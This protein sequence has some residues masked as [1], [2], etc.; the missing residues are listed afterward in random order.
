MSHHLAT[1]EQQQYIL[2]II[3]NA[4]LNMR[5]QIFLQYSVCISFEYIPEIKLLNYIFSF[6][7]SSMLFSVAT[8][9]IYKPI[10]NS[11]GLFFLYTFN[12]WCLL[13]F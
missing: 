13:S 6:L 11:Q 12:T 3:D 8:V 5:L 7:C 9:P 4:A 10:N 2:A 1:K